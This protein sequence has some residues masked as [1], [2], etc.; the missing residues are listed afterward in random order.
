MS[1]AEAMYRE[2]Q[3]EGDEIRRESSLFLEKV[4]AYTFPPEHS[5]EIVEDLGHLF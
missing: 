5:G 4:L 2:K 1:P 3:K